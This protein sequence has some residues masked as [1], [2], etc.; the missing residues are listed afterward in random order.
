MVP[1]GVVF[2]SLDLFRFFSS[3]LLLLGWLLLKK[4]VMPFLALASAFLTETA[5]G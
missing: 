1:A 4:P 3:L 2:V 5:L